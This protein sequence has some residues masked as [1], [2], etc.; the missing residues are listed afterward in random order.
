[1]RPAIVQNLLVAVIGNV[2]I[3][4]LQTLKLEVCHRFSALWLVLFLFTADLLGNRGALHNIILFIAIVD[5]S[6]GHRGSSKFVL[7]RIVTKFSHAVFVVLVAPQHQLP[8]NAL[9][10][11]LHRPRRFLLLREHLRVPR[12]ESMLTELKVVVLPILDLNG[13]KSH[14]G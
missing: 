5:I 2:F 9:L 12:P 3:L 10:R 1:M 11:I 13:L 14:V 8:K 7:S 4:A 6:F